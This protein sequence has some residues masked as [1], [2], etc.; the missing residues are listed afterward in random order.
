MFIH[1]HFARIALVLALLLV[2]TQQLVAAHGV[3]HPFH[4]GG[5]QKHGPGAHPQLCDLCVISALDNVASS[6]PDFGLATNATHV[7]M[8]QPVLSQSVVTPRHY[9]SRAPP[10][11][12]EING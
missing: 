4:D 9:Q 10:A 7:M 8:S 5:S 2:W 3:V 11:L 6:L 12:P 1:R